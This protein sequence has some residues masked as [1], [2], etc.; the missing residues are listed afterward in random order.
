MSSRRGAH[1]HTHTQ[2]EDSDVMG[3]DPRPRAEWVARLWA[4]AVP[5]AIFDAL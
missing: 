3:W 4:N 2:G 1:T 5:F